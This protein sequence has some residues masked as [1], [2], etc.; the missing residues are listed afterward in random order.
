MKQLVD[1][2]Q[3]KPNQTKPNPNP[4]PK[5][6]QLILCRFG[7]W[8]YYPQPHSPSSPS[9]L[10]DLTQFK[11]DWSSGEWNWKGVCVCVLLLCEAFVLCVRCCVSPLTQPKQYPSQC[12]QPI[13]KAPK[14]SQATRNPWSTPAARC[15]AFCSCWCWHSALIVAKHKVR[16]TNLVCLCCGLQISPLNQIRTL[17]HTCSIHLP[18]ALTD[19]LQ[20]LSHEA[21][22]PIIYSMT[23]N[24]KALTTGGGISSLFLV[25][26]LVLWWWW[27]HLLHI[28]TCR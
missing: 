8:I 21:E 19:R 5:P 16:C 25:L 20:S 7:W 13:A 3:T 14:Q 1:P 26:V 2:N 24:L 22:R 28:T 11:V 23:G 9:S 12:P 27:W 10:F 15:G 6:I 18:R 4:N 17:F